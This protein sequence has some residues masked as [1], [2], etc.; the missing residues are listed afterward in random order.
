VVPA[1]LPACPPARACP[2]ARHAGPWVRAGAGRLPFA[3]ATPGRGSG[4]AWDACPSRLPRRAMGHRRRRLRVTLRSRRT[5]HVLC[6]SGWSHG[7]RARRMMHISRPSGVARCGGAGRGRPST[8][9]LQP[10]ARVGA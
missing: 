3:P 4:L 1:I 2:R 7:P 8:A 9:T 6:A 5:A 10:A